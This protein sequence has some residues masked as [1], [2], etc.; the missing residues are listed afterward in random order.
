MEY[1]QNSIFPDFSFL[2]PPTLQPFF[3][4][5]LC[6]IFAIG[7]L[8][9]YISRDPWKPK[10]TFCKLFQV[11]KIFISRKWSISQFYFGIGVNA[12]PSRD[13]GPG[14]NPGTSH[15]FLYEYTHVTWNR[16][17]N[18]KMAHLCHPRRKNGPFWHFYIDAIVASVSLRIFLLQRFWQ[19]SGIYR[20][21]ASGSFV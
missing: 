11:Q 2:S 19:L 15:F 16:R 8:P 18:A 17:R 12:P 10:L 21:M 7:I 14:S 13:L 20:I 3:V 5:F 1:L 6:N 4:D 9:S